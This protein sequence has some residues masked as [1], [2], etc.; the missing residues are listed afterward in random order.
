MGKPIGL[1]CV[2]HYSDMADWNLPTKND[3]K[4][5]P[6]MSNSNTMNESPPKINP[7]PKFSS[8]NVVIF[9][10]VEDSSLL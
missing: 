5:H 6:T 9:R 7:C 3:L 2:K 10:F 4:N 1:Y 8:K